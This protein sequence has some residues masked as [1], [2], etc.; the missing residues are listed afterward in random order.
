MTNP[1]DGTLLRLMAKGAVP[2]WRRFRPDISRPSL[3]RYADNLAD[4]V[5]RRE[6]QLRD[7]LRAGPGDRPVVVHVAVRTKAGSSSIE[8]TGIMQHLQ[9]PDVLRRVLILGESGSGKTSAATHLTLGL[10]EERRAYDDER[11]A[12]EPVAVR[13]HAAGWNGTQFVGDW[14]AERLS[15]DYMVHRRVAHALVKTGRVLPLIDGFDELDSLETAKEALAWLNKPPWLHRPLVVLCRTEDFEEL[16]GTGARLQSATAMTMQA[17]TTTDIVRYLN[18]QQGD[19]DVADDAWQEVIEH[20]RNDP[21]GP[22]AT[23]LRTPLM[24]VLADSAQ[25]HDPAIVGRLARCAEP[26]EVRDSLLDQQIPTAAAG[27]ERG[28]DYEAFAEA[29][30]VTRWLA[31]LARHLDERGVAG[32][33]ATTIWLDQVWQLAGPIRCRV[34]H[35]FLCGLIAL[36]LFM[37]ALLNPPE[38]AESWLFDEGWPWLGVASTVIVAAVIGGSPGELGRRMAWSIPGRP[39]WKRLAEPI[40]LGIILSVGFGVVSLF[41]DGTPDELVVWAAL[42]APAFVAYG[43]IKFL[44]V[45][46]K[47][48]GRLV[49]HENRLVRDDATAAAVVGALVTAAYWTGLVAVDQIGGE[50]DG[51]YLVPLY[52]AGSFGVVAALMAGTVTGRHL[53]ASMIFSI[54]KTFPDH[55]ARFLEWARHSGLLGVSDAAYHFRHD[56]LR[57]WVKA[58]DPAPDPTR[59]D[60]LLAQ[61]SHSISLA[62][63][64]A[65]PPRNG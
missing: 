52:S 24:L 59:L 28:G 8:A 50:P 34:L 25:R 41:A 47:D 53:T 64:R 2:L 7:Q 29:D 30:A 12:D 23:A 54:T 15:A 51:S 42:A 46:V 33:D 16:R 44:L 56:T 39:W 18:D 11:R 19:E 60:R 32:G 9:R 65:L 4:Q 58:H 57:V 45:D 40:F 27:A 55:P 26:E 36:L 62:R 35:A 63:D 22:L 31:T 37:P 14:L 10:L 17:F 3:A 21:A 20:V 48:H 49:M 6:T 38:D 13:V 61:L 43:L 1:V 5:R